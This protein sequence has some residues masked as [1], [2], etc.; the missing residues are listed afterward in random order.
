MLNPNM[1]LKSIFG[2]SD[3]WRYLMHAMS[4]G[5]TSKPVIR[6]VSIMEAFS[7]E[8]PELTTGEIC[9]KT[10]IAKTTANRMLNTLFLTGLLEK[11]RVDHTY[12][13]GPL[14]YSL[15]NLFLRTTDLVRAADIVVKGINEIT[16]EVTNVSI[17]DR[18]N[19]ISI[20]REESSFSIRWNIH[21]GSVL[22]AYASSSGKVLLSQ[23]SG[24]DIDKIL[25]EERLE[26]FTSKTIVTK[27]ELKRNLQKIRET[28]VSLDMEEH[29]EGIVGIACLIHGA[30]GKVVAALNVAGP[31]HRLDKNRL[32][33]L[34]T[35]VRMGSSLISFRIGYQ[36]ADNPIHSFEEIR[37]WW[38]QNKMSE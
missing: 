16:E 24:E 12:T 9:Q 4:D 5:N 27:T 10:G 6:V 34:T 11:N 20:M 1:G 31:K 35:V 25:P 32:A 7:M 2:F 14:M 21:V 33:L 36:D 17:L 13:V 38:E 37:S 29:I 22:P 28:G 30:S 18:G 23:F 26:A 19:V 8:E 3:I 15:G